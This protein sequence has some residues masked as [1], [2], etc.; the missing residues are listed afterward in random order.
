MTSP[1]F[2]FYP[3]DFLADENVAL[4]SNR[5]IGCYI[6]LLCYCWREGS[7]PSDN[8]KIARLCG[9]PEI[10]MAQLWSAIG[11]CFSSA[12]D[13][14][15]RLI[16]KRLAMEV[17]KQQ[18]YRKERSESGKK[19]AKALW[20][21]QLKPDGSAMAKPMAKPMANDGS[22]SSSLSLPSLDMSTYPLPEASTLARSRYSGSVPAAA[23]SHSCQDN[24]P[25]KPATPS[26]T[27]ATP[28]LAVKPCSES[29]DV[30]D[31]AQRLSHERLD[32]HLPLLTFDCRDTPPT[33]ELT[34]P[35]VDMFS[36]GF[37][38][39]DILSECRKA[40]VWC[41]CNPAKIKTAKG[42]KTFLNSWLSRAQNNPRSNPASPVKP[43]FRRIADH[44]ITSLI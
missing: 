42:M 33:W 22:S 20:D 28:P 34:Q 39:I 17:E 35:L 26:Q 38:N 6:K 27:N 19:G 25:K 14:P 11:P 43:E 32:R 2:Q 15:S 23:D 8:Q 29:T 18:A 16:N 10:E 37:P 31:V 40:R 1:A 9:E 41:E 12:T 4:M 21:K 44:T 3:A 30:M 36:L 24:P 7:I 5:E 13:T